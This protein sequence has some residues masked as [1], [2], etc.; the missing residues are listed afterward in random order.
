MDIVGSTV[1]AQPGLAPEVNVGGLLAQ[2][3]NIG[4][5]T[6]DKF[7]VVP[8]LGVTLG[9]QVTDNIQVFGKINNLFDRRYASYCAYFETEGVG[10]PIT[11]NLHDPRSITI[12]Q[13]ISVFGGVKITF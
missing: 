2:P 8:E 9:Y 13:P 3:T 11:D 6:D 1:V 12:G 7:A 4:R 10:Q 5:F